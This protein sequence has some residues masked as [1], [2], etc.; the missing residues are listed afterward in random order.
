MTHRET[1]PVQREATPAE[2]RAQ[3]WMNLELLAA[4]KDFHGRLP[5][6]YRARIEAMTDEE[7]QMQFVVFLAMLP[8]PMRDRIERCVR[9]LR[10]LVPE[11]S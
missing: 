6:N 8:T 10:P 5:E 2:V 7:A 9:Y 3:L 4:A 1:Q 11:V